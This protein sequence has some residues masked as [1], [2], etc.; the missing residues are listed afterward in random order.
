[1]SEATYTHR[2]LGT[3]VREH[4]GGGTPPR[5]MSAYWKGDI[6]WASVKDFSERADVITDTQ[7]RIT[8]AGLNASASRLISAG[9]P[10]VC[11]RMAVGR[12][13]I[14][15][16][17]I[18]INQDVK[19]L[20]PAQG[21]SPAYLLKLL[22]FIQPQAE[23]QAVGS[24]V[25]GIRIRDY[26]NIQAPIA[27]PEAQV[28]IAAV[29]RTLDT[30][31]YETEALIAKL[32][33]V[34]QGLLHD[35]LTRGIDANGELRPPQSEAPHL[36]KQSPLGWIPLEWH[37]APAGRLCA[38]ITKGSTPAAGKMSEGDGDFPFL[39]VDNL[40][41]DGQLDRKA[42]SFFVTTKT[43]RGELSRSVC[44]PGDVLTNIVGPPL[45]KL[46][47]ITHKIGEVNINQAVALFRPK[48]LVLSEFLLLWIGSSFAKC[49]FWRRAKQTSGQVNLTLALCHELPVADLPMEEQR[50]II[51]QIASLD[52]RLTFEYSKFQKLAEV[53][54]GVMDDLLTGRVRVTPLLANESEGSA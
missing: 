10:L 17:A 31:I 8:S 40:T 20:F 7:E 12:T 46:C 51:S 25:K 30:F 44:F 4:V 43:H 13:A 48:P 18:A 34:K 28:A 50:A 38:I 16:T 6:P 45:G 39:R 23:S 33:A 35:L 52:A 24:T 22:Q 15:S 53:R 5:Q 32:K 49:W 19:A 3:L 47:L 26:L 21:V 36:F 27:G 1:M 37:L 2:P 29:L 9:T 42:S 11:T 41:F 54:S 14:P